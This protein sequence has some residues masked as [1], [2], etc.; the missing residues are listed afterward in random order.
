MANPI[1]RPDGT[2]VYTVRITLKPG[3]DDRLIEILQAAPERGMAAVVRE[4]MRTGTEQ[5]PEDIAWD[6][7]FELPDLGIE[8]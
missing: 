5:N 3:R 8:L 6:D 7:G 4:T 1:I 2:L